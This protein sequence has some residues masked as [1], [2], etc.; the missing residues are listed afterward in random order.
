MEFAPANNESGFVP[1]GLTA[2]H[3]GGGEPLAAGVTAT[4]AG[5]RMTLKKKLTRTEFRKRADDILM[6]LSLE[7]EPFWQDSEEKQAQR[8]K[9]AA[10][11]PLYFC[12]TYLP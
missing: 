2:N 1:L 5:G 3:P 8:L 12:R 4:E 11:D 9:K 6:R 7:V 10:A